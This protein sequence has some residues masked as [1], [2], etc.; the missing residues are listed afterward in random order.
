MPID[1]FTGESRCLNG[2]LIFSNPS[3]A[4]FATGALLVIVLQKLVANISTSHTF[5]YVALGIFV[6]VFSSY[7]NILV[8]SGFN[9][10]GINNAAID[11]TGSWLAANSSGQVS[12]ISSN[13]PATLTQDVSGSS[14]VSIIACSIDIANPCPVSGMDSASY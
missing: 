7:L 14:S 8:R 4:F 10:P 1:P 2:A 5:P 12:I 11:P 13:N 3:S 6:F 9:Q